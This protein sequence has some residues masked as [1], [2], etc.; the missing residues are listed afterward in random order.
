MMADGMANLFKCDELHVDER[1]L[2]KSVFLKWNGGERDKSRD[3]VYN[4][5][6]N[7]RVLQRRYR[8]TQ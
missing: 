1:S 3:G 7:V 2:K 5:K 8:I 4:T 6:R